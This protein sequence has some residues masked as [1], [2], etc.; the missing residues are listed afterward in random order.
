[1]KRT[2]AAIMASAMMLF[3]L[4]RLLRRRSIF[5]EHSP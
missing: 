5:G 1:M 4:G 3:A 2:L